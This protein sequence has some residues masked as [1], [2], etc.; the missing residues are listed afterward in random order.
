METNQ[1]RKNF[2]VTTQLDTIIKDM[3]A[4]GY[5]EKEF[6]T[7]SSQL[8]SFVKTEIRQKIKDKV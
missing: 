3:R 6:I 4:Q 2:D 5:G 7:L 1:Q 8:L